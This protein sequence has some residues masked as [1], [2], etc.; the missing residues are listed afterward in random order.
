MAL[1]SAAVIIGPVPNLGPKIRARDIQVG[2][3]L[4]PRNEGINEERG[5]ERREGN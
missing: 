3:A 1:G 5:R 2:F 4:N